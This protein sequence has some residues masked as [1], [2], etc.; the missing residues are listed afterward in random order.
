L[1][2]VV[3]KEHCAQFLDQLLAQF[4]PI[5]QLCIFVSLGYDLVFVWLST[6]MGVAL[7]A[8]CTAIIAPLNL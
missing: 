6:H 1:L 8:A 3:L 5:P 4:N 2:A 7:K